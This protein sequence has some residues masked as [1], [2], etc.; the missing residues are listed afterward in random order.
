MGDFW[1]SID[2]N[3]M[4]N[5]EL[6]NQIRKHAFENKGQECCGL[7][8]KSGES[9]FTYKCK[10]ISSNKMN[11]F[12]LSPLDYLR[13]W[14]DGKNKIIGFYHSQ[15]NSKPSILDTIIY[16]NHK[17]PSFIYSFEV[18]DIIEVTNK[19]SKYNKYLGKEF[20]IGKQD[21]FSLIRE[22]YLNE[23]EINITDLLRDDK[24]LEKNPN[25]AENIHK[26][27]G[28]TKIN[29]KDIIEGNIVEFNYG[30]FG[31]YLDGDLL[32]HHFRNKYSNIERL[33]E[34]WKKRITSCYKHESQ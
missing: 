11:H 2:S 23:Y 8:L 12:E 29:F 32:L 21:C 10:N 6:R 31:I 19:H 28:F 14:D 13:A 26:K 25:I 22:F 18:D 24:W 30:H 33:D 16:N 20:E 15:I 4:L 17:L 9:I 27:E 7:I 34:I 3:N 1:Q 5:V